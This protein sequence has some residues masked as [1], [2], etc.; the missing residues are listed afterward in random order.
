MSVIDSYSFWIFSLLRINDFDFVIGIVYVKPS[1]NF[2]YFLELLQSCI[3]E[4]I[5]QN[6]D[7]LILI[8]GDFNSRMNDLSEVDEPVIENTNLYPMRKSFDKVLSRRGTLL[9]DFMLMNNFILLNG[10]TRGDTEGLFTFSSHV[11]NSVIDLAW[12]NQPYVDLIDTFEV[13]QQPS[14]SDHYP[15]TVRVNIPVQVDNEIENICNLTSFTKLS[16]NPDKIEEYINLIHDECLNFPDFYSSNN[17]IDANFDQLLSMIKNVS[18]RLSLVKTIHV[19]SMRN[20]RNPWFDYQCK[21]AK[22]V[23][24]KTHKELV[25][26]NFTVEAKLSYSLAKKEYKNITRV[27]K[28]NYQQQIKDKC[29]NTKNSN[30]FWRTL[31]AFNRKPYIENP[32]VIPAWEEF[33]AN[34]YPPL[35]VNE[36]TYFGVFDRD[37]DSPITVNEVLLALKKMKP[38]KTPGVDGVSI[39]FFKSLPISAIEIITSLFNDILFYET[40]PSSWSEIILT[41]LHKKGD[42]SNPSNYR[43]IAL[44]NCISKLFTLIL[45]DRLEAWASRNNIVNETQNGFRRRRSC[46]D[47]IYVLQSVIHFT[48]RLSKGQVFA[49]FIDFKRAFDS[50]SHSLLWRKLYDLGVSLKFIRILKNLYDSAFFRVRVN[51]KYSKEIRVTEGVL[52]GESLSPLIFILFISDFE[53]F[54]RAE[55]LEGVNIDGMI[56]LLLLLYADDAVALTNTPVQMRKLLTAIEKYCKLNQ[57]TVN[58]QKTQIVNFRRNGRQTKEKFYFE[59][60]ELCVVKDYTYLGTKFSSSSLGRCA[61]DQSI[62]KARAATGAVLRTISNCKTDSWNCRVRLFESSIS[63]TLLYASY[64][65]G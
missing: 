9:N 18:S 3:D 20:Q 22:R 23:M 10:R 31:R 62:W 44:C 58:T 5:L 57:L 55:K 32:I 25:K 17:P 12:I 52:Q 42:K 59:N 50:I 26:N 41:L 11:G 56:D 51:N 1:L 48:L 61:I 43:G 33:Y 53:K 39:E 13:I 38:G 19:N 54:L 64:I 4:I 46:I 47:N 30:D 49:L 35:L 24:Q 7:K 6:P 40:T 27:K 34:V 2:E 29:A 8:I 16:W 14:A 15:V 28:M 45:S 36:L 60:Q 37:L 63:S 21:I 65:T